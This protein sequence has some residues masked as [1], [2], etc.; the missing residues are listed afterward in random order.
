MRPIR[1]S[2]T[3]TPSGLIE[4]PNASAQLG[5]EAEAD[6]RS[7]EHAE[8]HEQAG[9][10]H[11]VSASWRK[12]AHRC[13]RFKQRREQHQVEDRLQDADRDPQRVVDEDAEVAAEDE[14]R[15]PG[16][17]HAADSR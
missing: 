2:T 10:E 5:D 8:L 14:P 15:V 3:T 7:A 17:L 16:E 9:N 12:A 6:A 13:D 1:A 4:S 11:V